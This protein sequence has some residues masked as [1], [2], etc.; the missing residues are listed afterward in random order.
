V[1][2]LTPHDLEDV[3]GDVLN[4]GRAT[5]T[6]PRAKEI[7]LG[8]KSRIEAVRERCSKAQRLSVA[9]L[10]WMDPIYCSGHW[11]P[12]LIRYAGGEE[13]LG[14][15]REPSTSVAWHELLKK[16]PEVILLTVCGY[17]VN[18]TLGEISVLT[19][20]EGWGNLKAVT[21]GSVYILD[22]QSYYSR[23]GPRLVDGLEIVA[24][25]L[26][27]ELFPDYTTP[28]GSAYSLAAR[29]FI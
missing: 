1:L 19:S 20:R 17:D 24:Y 25:L 4:V 5:G 13:V 11:M 22:G 15:H 29:R 27:P 14:R 7:V 21:D 28:I 10:E 2:S 26:H 18:R 3:L 16:D 6:L 12:E 8:F 9:C 23:S